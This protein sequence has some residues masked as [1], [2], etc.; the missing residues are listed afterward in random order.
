MAPGLHTLHGYF[1]RDLPPALTVDSGDTVV[2]STLDAGWADGPASQPGARRP[3]FK[4]WKPERRGDG[5]ALCGPIEVRGAEPGMTLEVRIGELRPARGGWTFAGGP[6]RELNKRLGL[7]ERV[8]ELHWSLDPVAGVGRDG[9]GRSVALRPFMGVLGM[10]PDEPGRHSTAPPRITGGN[11]DC[12]DL[13]TGSS[14]FLPIAV[15]GALFSVGDGHAAQGR[16]TARSR[17]LR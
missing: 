3:L 10:P 7:H 15:P 11:I 2:Y 12:K 16:A 8:E 5:H 13:V 9:Y 14:L 4:D 17:E 6:G 1:D